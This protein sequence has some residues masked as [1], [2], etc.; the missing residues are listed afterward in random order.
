M[1]RFGITR[2]RRVRSSLCR[3]SLAGDEPVVAWWVLLYDYRKF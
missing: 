2:E 3:K 1:A